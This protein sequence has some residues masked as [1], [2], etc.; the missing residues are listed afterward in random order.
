MIQLSIVPSGIFIYNANEV[1]DIFLDY[2]EKP[3]EYAKS[4]HQ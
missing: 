2:L 1:L 3:W 4:V